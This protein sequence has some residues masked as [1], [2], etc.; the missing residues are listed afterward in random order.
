MFKFVQENRDNLIRDKKTRFGSPIFRGVRD[1]IVSKVKQ[2]G[3][4]VELG[5]E[6]LGANLKQVQQHI[7]H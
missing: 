6:V 4:N 2:S 1:T 3:K 5:K 7:Y